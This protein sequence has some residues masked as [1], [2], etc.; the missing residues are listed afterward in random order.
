MIGGVLLRWS[1][2]W[3]VL[4]SL[5]RTSEALLVTFGFLLTF[6]W[7]FLFSLAV[8]SI[9]GSI[10]LAVKHL[11]FHNYSKTLEIV[12][13]CLQRFLGILWFGLCPDMQYKYIRVYT[14]LPCLLP[15][16][17]PD[18]DFFHLLTHWPLATTNNWET[19]QD[20]IQWS[21]VRWWYASGSK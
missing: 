1:S 5:Q 6:L 21:T 10:L 8:W 4:P 20:S 9:P 3:Q 16:L 14:G 7:P 18:I 15:L 13:H 17:F 12:H 11:P 19:F 2:F